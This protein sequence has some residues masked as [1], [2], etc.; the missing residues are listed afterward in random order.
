MSDRLCP[1]CRGEGKPNRIDSLCQIVGDHLTREDILFANTLDAEVTKSRRRQHNISSKTHSSSS[2]NTSTTSNP[3]KSKDSETAAVPPV[4][5]STPR[6]LP[7]P[8]FAELVERLEGSSLE[9]DYGNVAVSTNTPNHTTRNASQIREPK[10]LASGSYT[11]T[12]TSTGL[13][14]NSDSVKYDIEK[15]PNR[16]CRKRRHVIQHTV[17]G[18]SAST[19]CTKYGGDALAELCS[20]KDEPH[21]RMTIENYRERMEDILHNLDRCDLLPML[22]RARPLF[23]GKLNF[24]CVI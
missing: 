10:G 23:K 17:D 20:P 13:K 19:K 21:L 11:K 15:K 14:I 6:L 4:S 1:G 16:T 18:Y 22:Q 3:N 12:S 8:N 24:R 5:E 7:P 9:F 2:T